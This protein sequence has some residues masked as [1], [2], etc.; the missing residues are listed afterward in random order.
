MNL[1]N[2]QINLVLSLVLVIL[3]MHAHYKMNKK[4]DTNRL[5]M[6][7]MSS[8]LSI[9]L[10]EVLSVVLNNP[11]HVEWIR[12]HKF[13]NMVGFVIAPIIPFIGYLF[14]RKWLNRFS[15]DIIPINWLLLL[16]LIV[17]GI[18]SIL[19][20]KWGFIFH[21]TNSNVYER[22]PW[23]FILPTVSYFLFAYNLWF[24]YKYRKRLYQ[25][26]IVVMSAFYIAPAIFTYVQLRY[27]FILTTWNSAAIIV[28]MTYVFI[29][30]DQCY[31]DNLTGLENRMAY[32]HYAQNLNTKR[33]RRVSIMF[34]DLDNLKA[35]NDQFG[36]QAGDDILKSF[37]CLLRTCFP[38][39]KKLIRLG[40]DEFL[41]VLEANN[42]E[43]LLVYIEHLVQLA[44]EQ[45][46][47]MNKN[48]Q[49]EF[50]FG[51]V[52]HESGEAIEQLLKRADQQMYAH[53]LSR[54]EGKEGQL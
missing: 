27:A 22:G 37:A 20:Y 24:I 13:V 16:P 54:K 39:A 9:L 42:S 18:G 17:N 41:V 12:Y 19:S 53:K 5:F 44:E 30:N 6:W 28:I 38:T 50:S 33:L 29:L 25:S 21:V 3:L 52:K 8:T 36:H 45:N 49:I 4:T 23:F 11:N 2:L 47:Q 51:L 46:K 15:K 31:R 40:G 34:I 43:N 10:L 32:E 48:Y 14:V 1:Y 26:E 35:I 7:V